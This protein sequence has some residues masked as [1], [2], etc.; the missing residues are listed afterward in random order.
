MKFYSYYF[1][2]NEKKKVFFVFYKKTL[3]VLKN[4]KIK[5]N[6]ILLYYE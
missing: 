1:I 6:K 2:I 4:L 3:K 5:L